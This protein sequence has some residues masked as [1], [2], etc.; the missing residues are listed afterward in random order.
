MSKKAG[1]SALE[2]LSVAQ[3]KKMGMSDAQIK[4]LKGK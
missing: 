3:L 4:K 2:D 1:A